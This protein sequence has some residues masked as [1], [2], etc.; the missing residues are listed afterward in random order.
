MPVCGSSLAGASRTLW[1]AFELTN[2]AQRVV[3]IAECPICSLANC[4]PVLGLAGSAAGDG[5]PA[6]STQTP[7]GLPVKSLRAQLKHLGALS[8]NSVA[9]AQEVSHELELLTENAPLQEKAFAL[10]GV[11]RER[12]VSS[13][14]NRSGGA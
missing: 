10:L 13:D 4:K 7:T 6:A 11:E 2:P 8:L 9:L 3:L 5:P 12:V 14:R 1:T